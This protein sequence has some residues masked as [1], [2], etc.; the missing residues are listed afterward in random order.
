VHR[1]TAGSLSAV[2]RTLSPIQHKRDRVIGAA[3]IA[4]GI[5][6][7]K[8]LAEELRQKQKM[9]AIGQLAGGVAHDFNNLLTIINGYSN[10]LLCDPGLDAM[11][12]S[13]VEE[14]H[15]AGMR[16]ASLT[17][18]L[19]AFSRRLEPKVVNLSDRMS[20]IQSLLSRLIGEDVVLTIKLHPSLG[21]IK[22]DPGQLD[23]VVINLVVNARDAMPR[24]GKLTLETAT[25]DLDEAAVASRPPVRP[26][27][28][29]LLAVSDTGTGMD[30]H[31]RERVFEPF[32]TTKGPG[33][34][35]GL[36]LAVVHGII[37]QSG[38]HIEVE[39]EVGRGTTFKIFFPQVEGV[40]KSDPSHLGI[41]PALPGSETVLLVE[42]EEG[43]RK[44]ARH[45]LELAGYKVL[46]AANGGE[47]MFVAESHPGP[48]DVLVADVVMPEMGGCLL[49]ERLI[50]LRPGMKVLFVSGYTNDAVLRDG[51]LA[52]EIHFLQK[53][54]TPAML[55]RSVRKVLEQESTVEHAPQ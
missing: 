54:F 33:K 22:V 43:V 44:M 13:L 23:Q 17:T 28:Y 2:A 20:S 38:G 11:T 6:S 30:E 46:E 45:S 50:A 21:C 51:I 9:A 37:A 35:T 3:A 7:R 14:I 16:S 32:F 31:T 40:R 36:G 26:G 1:H 34:G 48:I 15:K 5:S 29:S 12:H 4:Q 8:R 42:D 19:L 18:Q 10:M 27:R 55:T 47:G 41:K 24:G 39:S 53:P 25:V 49:A 52:A